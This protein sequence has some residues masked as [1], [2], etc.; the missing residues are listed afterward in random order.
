MNSMYI[1]IVLFIYNTGETLTG[2]TCLEWW[3]D[4]RWDHVWKKF[5]YPFAVWFVRDKVPVCPCISDVVV[6]HEVVKGDIFE[7]IGRR[8]T[9]IW[10]VL[11][12]LHQDWF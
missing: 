11:Y 12:K 1:C 6:M 2:L 4:I 3:C 8:R 10:V 7:F 5:F 9:N